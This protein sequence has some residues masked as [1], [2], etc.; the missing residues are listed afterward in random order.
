MKQDT[1]SG[2]TV[3]DLEIAV[4]LPIFNRNQGNI[5]RVQAALTP[6]YNDVKRVELS[7]YERLATTFQPYP[8]ARRRA[9]QYRTTIL[10]HAQKSLELTQ[11]AYREG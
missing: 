10:P 9:E 7:F 8:N 1:G 6:A 4:P 3:V 11:I 2:Y 5:F